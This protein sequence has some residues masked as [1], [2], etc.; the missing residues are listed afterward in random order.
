MTPYPTYTPV[1]TMTPYPTYTPLPPT[2]TPTTTG[3]SEWLKGH[4]WSIKVVEVQT[5]TELDGTHPTEDTFVLVNVQWKG[6]NLA[7]MHTI[8]GIDFQ[9]VDDA[10]EQYDVAG[11]IFE[12]KTYDSYGASAKFQK[13]NWMWTQTRGTTDK[14]F[15]LVYDVPSSATSLKLW[16]QD[17]PLVDL[18]L[19]LT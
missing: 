13:G 16:F 3:V 15:R 18:G 17:F 1:P 2:P 5:E 8:S 7:E 4:F 6:N 10:G 9:L 14:I 11:M 12:D 19:E